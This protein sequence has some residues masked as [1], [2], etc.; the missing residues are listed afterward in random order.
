MDASL[1]GKPSTE[2]LA[3]KRIELKFVLDDLLA[4]VV[5]DWAR[6]HLGVD[7]HCDPELGDSYEVS[8]LYLD[9]PDFDV[10]HRR[11]GIG[12]C[13]HRLRRYGQE[14]MVWLETKRKRNF[15]V[16]KNRTAVAESELQLLRDQVTARTAGI[17]E[18]VS[19]NLDQSEARS[20]FEDSKS[21]WCGDWYTKRVINR[22][23][24]PAVLVHYRRFARMATI[25]DESLRLTIDSELQGRATN[26][27]NIPARERSSV[28]EI[29]KSKIL[30]LKF[31]NT[32]PTLF[33]E[34]LRQHSIIATQFSK[35]RSTVSLCFPSLDQFLE[36][37]S[38]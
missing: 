26:D 16:R 27:W 2:R 31:H 15:V 14:Q 32:M 35:F 7:A 36:Q 38:E 29:S 3:D 18:I 21:P 5:K 23:L 37:G 12:R 34:L 25:G 13:K 19:S 20:T 17:D 9:S 22:N 8:T 10:F 6:Q 1:V 4:E 11:K 24:R 33:K 30:E 28:Q